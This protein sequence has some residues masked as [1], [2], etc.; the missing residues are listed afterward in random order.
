[1]T[2]PHHTPKTIA[3]IYVEPDTIYRRYDW[4]DCYDEARDATTYADTMPVIAHPPC[5][6]WSRLRAFTTAP[7]GEHQLSLH[8]L[9][10][11]RT[12]GGVLEHPASS[13]LWKLEG[14]PRPGEYDR[15]GGWLFTIDQ[16]AFNHPA[17]KRTTFYIVGA[18]PTDLPAF[19]VW[20]QHTRTV[21]SQH[22]R[23]RLKTPPAMAHWLVELANIIAYNRRPSRAKDKQQ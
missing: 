16:G 20:S 18:K 2:Q 3:A 19:G 9:A 14:M 12:R 13:S 15:H 5:R 22:S 21:Q 4:I 7:A 17:Q 8:A 10:I 6:T 11:V 1:M 23:D